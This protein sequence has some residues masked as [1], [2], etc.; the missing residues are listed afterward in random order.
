MS[1]HL[2]RER[3]M[4][5]D[6]LRADDRE[7]SFLAG[8]TDAVLELRHVEITQ[9]F[10]K[11]AQKAGFAYEVIE[12]RGDGRT[13]Y[14]IHWTHRGASFVGFKQPPPE[15]KLEDALLAGCAAL[16]ENQWCLEWLDK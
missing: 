6:W 3:E 11:W 4:M 10:L 9:Q 2:Q 12:A 13:A 5:L 14:V 8:D 15:T 1:G 7:P 16:L